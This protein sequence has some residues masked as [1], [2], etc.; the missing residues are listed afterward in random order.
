MTVSF[1]EAENGQVDISMRA[2]P[3]YDVGSVALK[4]GG[5]GHR[6]ASGCTLEGPFED[7]V[8]LVVG[9]LKDVVAEAEG[10]Q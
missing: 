5:G 1:S 9:Y 6:L 8:K 7:T 3:G 10:A 4:L 2:R